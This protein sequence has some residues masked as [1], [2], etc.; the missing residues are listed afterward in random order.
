MP[1]AATVP[2]VEGEQLGVGGRGE[3]SSQDGSR[4][5]R[6]GERDGERRGERRRLKQREGGRERA[7]TWETRSL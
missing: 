4:E 3:E 7:S 2:K 1:V 5:D 6:A